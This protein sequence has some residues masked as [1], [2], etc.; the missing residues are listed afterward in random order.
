MGTANATP[1]HTP[2]SSPQ[3]PTPVGHGVPV[4]DQNP[5]RKQERASHGY[6]RKQTPTEKF[7]MP[8]EPLYLQTH[9]SVTGSD[10]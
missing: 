3:V 6:I 7:E 1:H 5:D 2:A 4:H 9:L 10:I 8:P